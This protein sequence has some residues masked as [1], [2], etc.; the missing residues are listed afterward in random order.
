MR[1][2]FV[3]FW[4]WIVGLNLLQK[5][6]FVKT[7]RRSAKVDPRKTMTNELL[8]PL[9]SY[10]AEWG[11]RTTWHPQPYSW[12]LRGKI[13]LT[14]QEIVLGEVHIAFSFSAAS[15]ILQSWQL[16]ASGE[17]L[18]ESCCVMACIILA[19]PSFLK[20]VSVRDMAPTAGSAYSS[21]R[22]E[23]TWFPTERHDSECSRVKKTITFLGYDSV[24]RTQYVVSLWRSLTKTVYN[25]NDS[26]RVQ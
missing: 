19:C 12:Q 17:G 16:L 22:R 14:R 21:V 24:R 11:S 20:L 10:A 5:F 9:M 7:R 8:R 23:T 25:Y 26:F 15:I 2:T 18:L 4:S 1:S 6:S 3:K 13:F